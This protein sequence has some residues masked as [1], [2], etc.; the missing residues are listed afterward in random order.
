MQ[1]LL[2]LCLCAGLQLASSK[3]KPSIPLLNKLSRNNY[4]VERK[5]S[6]LLTPLESSGSGESS[7]TCDSRDLQQYF[8]ELRYL[9]AACVDELVFDNCCQAQLLIRPQFSG[10][11]PINLRRGLRN[12]YCD[13]DSHGGGWMVIFRGG[14][15]KNRLWPRPY[16]MGSYE[17]G[18]GK[19]NKG[20]WLGLSHIHHFTQQQDTEL[21]VELTQNETKFFAHYSQFSVTSKKSGYRLRVGGYQETSTLPDSLSHSNGFNFSI[22]YTNDDVE[23]QYRYYS[24]CNVIFADNWWHGGKGNE[25][26]TKVS[27]LRNTVDID[28]IRNLPTGLIW[29]IDGRKVGFDSGEMK[30]RPKKW[31]C[32]RIPNYSNNVLQ[33]A[34]LAPSYPLLDPFREIEP[35]AQPEV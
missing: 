27:L 17:Y 25:S 18:Y 10:I 19:F 11:Y 15:G 9:S 16:R 33:R 21:L 30:I 26:C 13:M 5:G 6:N 35:S 23:D 22:S 28:T 24:S 34:F 2:I 4:V 1:L 29:E 7:L 12:M 20:F 31:E 8:R 3:V 14:K 32:G